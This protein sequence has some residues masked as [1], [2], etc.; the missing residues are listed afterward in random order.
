[1]EERSYRLARYEIIVKS[2]DIIW[3]K[4]HGGFA[5]ANSGKC[6]IEGDI[7]FIGPSEMDEIGFLKNEFLEYLRQLPQ[8]NRTKYYCPRYTLYRCRDGRV[9]DGIEPSTKK[10]AR[11]H[12]RSDMSSMTSADEITLSS[13]SPVTRI[14]QVKGKLGEAFCCCKGLV[15]FRSKKGSPEE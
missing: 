11:W 5:N 6:F 8:W 14:R 7:L 13:G 1:M 9:W 3:W 12:D 15:G 4:A 10:E 2:T